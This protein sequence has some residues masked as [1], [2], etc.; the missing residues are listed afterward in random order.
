MSCGSAFYNMVVAKAK[1]RYL[2]VFDL[3]DF[4]VNSSA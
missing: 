1:E 4:E 3:Y 2:Y